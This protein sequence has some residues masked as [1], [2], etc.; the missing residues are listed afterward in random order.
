VQEATC[1]VC[2]GSLPLLLLLL[3]LLLLRRQLTV[4]CNLLA[5]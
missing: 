5:G 3:L 1:N 4:S 2:I